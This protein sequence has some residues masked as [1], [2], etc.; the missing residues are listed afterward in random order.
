MAGALSRPSFGVP[1]QNFLSLPSYVK[2]IILFYYDYRLYDDR[3]QIKLSPSLLLLLFLMIPT[4]MMISG[5]FQL[6]SGF[7]IFSAIS[8]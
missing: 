4:V 2:K 3:W 7:R 5:F 6:I 1:I 8:G